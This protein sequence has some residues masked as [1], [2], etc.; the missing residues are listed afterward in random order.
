[1]KHKSFNF[2]R[3][4]AVMMITSIFTFAFVWTNSS[5]SG[6]IDDETQKQK[7]IAESETNTDEVIPESGLQTAA[8]TKTIAGLKDAA[9]ITAEP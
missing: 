2:N 1:M 4:I 9:T 8:V 3:I 6:R 5:A 7:T